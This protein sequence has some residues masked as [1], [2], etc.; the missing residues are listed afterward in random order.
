MGV[1]SVPTTGCVF[2]PNPPGQGRTQR[3]REWSVGT[4]NHSMAGTVTLL[5][6]CGLWYTVRSVRTYSLC[7]IILWFSSPLLAPE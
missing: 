4:V 6:S 5:A 7:D 3:T 2:P 1:D